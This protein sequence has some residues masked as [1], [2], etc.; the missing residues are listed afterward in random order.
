MELFEIVNLALDTYLH[1]SN[2]HLFTLKICIVKTTE[3][4]TAAILPINMTKVPT[5][6][7]VVTTKIFDDRSRIDS[8]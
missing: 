7:I 1:L 6:L 4:A 2:K 5:E 8:R 3:T